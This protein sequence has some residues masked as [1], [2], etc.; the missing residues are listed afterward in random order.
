ME[1]L[2]DKGLAYTLSFLSAGPVQSAL[3]GAP[4][5]EISDFDGF[6]DFLRRVQTPYYEEARRHF[7]DPDLLDDFADANEV[8]PYL[9]DELQRIAAKYK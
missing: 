5:C 1:F 3:G 2:G 9:P 8:L 4:Q 6:V 7:R